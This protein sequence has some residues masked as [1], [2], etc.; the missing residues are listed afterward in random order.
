MVDIGFIELLICALIGL[1]VLGP[2][3]LPMVARTAGRW[4]GRG[5]RL[6]QQFMREIDGEPLRQGLR[7]HGGDE[8]DALRRDLRETDQQLRTAGQ[9]DPAN[10]Q[11]PPT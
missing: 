11:E 1:L 2:E 4:V 6:T 5:R 9:T 3:R 10:R 8:L 7:D